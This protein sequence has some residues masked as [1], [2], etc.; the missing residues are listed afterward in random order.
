METHSTLAA[1]PWS[2]VAMVDVVICAI[3]IAI[4]SPLVVIITTCAPDM[5]RPRQ[6]QYPTA[7]S[8]HELLQ[9]QQQRDACT[10]HSLATQL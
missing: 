8:L 5:V 6:S 4:A 9:S 7:L 3:P 10:L 1:Q 2:Q